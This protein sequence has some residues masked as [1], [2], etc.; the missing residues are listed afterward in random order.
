[1]SSFP[2]IMIS[3]TVCRMSVAT[4]PSWATLLNFSNTNASATGF[5]ILRGN[6]S[7]L[8]SNLSHVRDLSLL[9]IR[10]LEF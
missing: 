1:M 6:T 5:S 8:A 2:E 4:I 10:K 3:R 7:E 9:A